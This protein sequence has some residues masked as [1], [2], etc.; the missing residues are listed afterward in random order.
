MAIGLQT[1]PAHPMLACN[2]TLPGS[3]AGTCNNVLDAASLVK[4]NLLS[5][6]EST[7]LASKLNVNS[8]CKL[9]AYLLNIEYIAC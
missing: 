7:D 1:Q 6:R 8:I 2:T 3:Q 5:D 9:I 4:K